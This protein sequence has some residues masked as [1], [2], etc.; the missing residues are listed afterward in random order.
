MSF[1]I[2][3]C[4]TTCT[5]HAHTN[6]ILYGKEQIPSKF[7]LNGIKSMKMLAKSMPW[8]TEIESKTESLIPWSG[9]CSNV[10]FI[11]IVE[12]NTL[13]YIEPFWPILL[14]H[15]QRDDETPYRYVCVRGLC[16]CVGRCL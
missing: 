15:R 4:T 16:M 3:S 14:Y 5:A 2:G 9:A 6:Q 8:H 10:V 13:A 12:E 7:V 11:E 1:A